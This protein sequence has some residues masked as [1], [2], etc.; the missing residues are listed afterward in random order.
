[1]INKALAGAV[2]QLVR[3]SRQAPRSRT[4]EQHALLLICWLVCAAGAGAA[5]P[6]ATPARHPE[7]GRPFIRH[8]A[9]REYRASD[10]NWAIAQDDRGVMYVGNNV[11][12]L[13][14][15]GVS[16]RLIQVPNESVIRSLAKDD[17]GRIYVGGLGEVGYLAPDAQGQMRFV[18]LLD[19][20]PEADRAFADVFRTFVTP[21]GVYF[22]SQQRLF[23]WADGRMR[24][25]RPISKFH[26]A[27]LVGETL[28]IGQPETG[29]MRMVG[30]ALEPL[31]DGR[32]FAD[33][34]FPV[35]LPLGDGQILIG[36]QE[37]GLFLHDGA[38]ARP[39]PTE[40]DEVLRKGLYRGTVLPDGTLALATLSAGLVIV[41][42]E[43][44]LALH[45]AKADGLMNETV[46]FVFADRQGA[47]W[48][49]L[50]SGIARVETPSPLSVFDLETSGL[51]GSVS[52]VQRHEGILYVATGQGVYRL[53]SRSSGDPHRSVSASSLADF[54]RIPITG[55]G[56]S[57]QAWWFLSMDDPERKRPSQL[58]VAVNEGVYRIEGERA[59]PVKESVGG[60][61]QPSVLCR[62]RRDPNRVF[63]GLFDGLASLRL[64]EGKWVDEGRVAGIPD[65]VRTI[66]E[67]ED[68]RLWLGTTVRGAVR[69]DFSAVIA[70]GSLPLHPQVERFGAA[71]GLSSPAVSVRLVDGKPLFMTPEEI[72]R[73][74]EP[75]RRFVPDGTF[76]VVTFDPLGTGDFG[77]LQQDAQGRVWING[78]H[79]TAVAIRQPDGSYR[80]EKQPFLRFAGFGVS[81]VFADADGVVWLAGLEGLVR[82]DGNLH[83]DYDADFPA[84][85]RRVVVNDDSAM[86][87]GATE[88]AGGTPPRL[89][90]EQSALRFEFAAPSFDDESA[91]EYQHFLEGHDRGW[92][93]WAKE[94]RR[95][96]TN[97]PF[98]NYQFRVRA[99]NRYGHESREAGY[100]F[101]ILPPWYRTWWAYAAYLLAL[102]AGVFVVDRLQRRRVIGQ[103]RARSRFRETQLR[104]E[105][106]ETLARS[107]SERTRSVELLSE[108]G[109]EIT[110]SLDFDTISMRLYE[111]VNQLLDATVVGVGLYH[112]KKQEIEY[113]LAVER[114]K[115]YEPYVRNTG[116]K[117]QF[118]V[119]CIDNRKPVFINDVA[120]EWSRYLA[121][122]EE[123]G[124]R[125]E[126]GSQSQ[127]PQSLL[128][129]PLATSD[130][131][132]GV[133][134]V[135][136]FQKNAYTEYHLNLLQNLAAYTTI[137]L[138]NAYTYRQ[139][140]EQESN[141]RQR[142]AEL[143]TVN[144][145]SQALASELKLDAL[146]PLVGEQVRQVFDAQVAYVALIDR[147]T[148]TIH[149]PY[150][151]GD[152]FGSRPH[153]AGMT[154][155]IIETG[156]PLLLNENI[157]EHSAQLKIQ[158]VGV[159][160]KSYLGV[161]ILVG[162]E[163]IGV[164]SVQ[165][166]EQEGRFGDTDLRLLKTIAANV[167]VAI[168]NARLFEET[169]QARATAE[170]ADA[171]KSSFLSTVSHELRTPLTSVLGFAKIIKKR[172]E[173]RIFPLVKSEDKKVRQ[174]MQ[175]VGDNLQVVVSEGE[176]LTK[177][178]DDVLDLAKI[179]A[180]KLEW[181]METLTVAEIVERA[182]AATSSLLE[183]RGLKLVKDVKPD[184]P[185]VVGDRDRLIQVVINLIS[186][187]VKF[188]ERGSVTCRAVERDGGV[189]VSV[190]DTGMGIAPADQ[191]KVFERFKQVGDTL[192]DK[193][194]GTGLGLPICKEIVEHHGGRVWVESEL[195]G[196]STFSFTL[197]AKSERAAASAALSLESLVK[198]LRERVEVS[199][200]MTRDGQPAIL[201]VDDDP[202]IRELLRQELGEAGY[203]IRLAADGREALSEIRRERPDLVI[204]D[205]MMPEINGFDVAA[206]LRNDPLTMDIPIMILSIVQD[207]ER[208]FRLGVDRYLTK[209]IDTEVLFREV[210]ALL[211][212][213]KSRKRVLVV[214][215]DASAAKTLAEVLQAR[216]YTVMEA[217]GQD[218]VARA[219]EM[220]P[221]IIILSSLV[222]Q[223]HEAVQSLRF[224]KGLENVLFLVYQ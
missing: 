122:Y 167:G 173:E 188:T 89:R 113:R 2:P 78:G 219:L 214:D 20:V 199:A 187:A 12:V 92:S 108:I 121:A 105:A 33:E 61:F 193:P 184:L 49:G 93:E 157:D 224:E 6:A 138:E 151:Y 107:E 212:Q 51:R 77:V 71:E 90:S 144:S 59:T 114:G 141:I 98:G 182:T 183:T 178:I 186:N 91:N 133:I 208:G 200:P 69:V 136:S 57:T 47:L 31:P 128:Y 201:A 43:G 79:E 81:S 3:R 213:G 25:W 152:T 10:Q 46:R 95:D 26:R 165:S 174:A 88:A 104:A 129:V 211:E 63:V 192:T 103:E 127:P 80:I 7:A 180:G 131:V 169:R 72:Y 18:S 154:S 196:G 99:R 68:G 221:D 205:V 54:V 70:G 197:P 34:I 13:E 40:A 146:I 198:Q 132:L 137:A 175:Q 83:K 120:S 45:L 119:W 117:N 111:R 185:E 50:D 124:R 123:P 76:K 74:E 203:R 147:A 155:R 153:G 204:L 87:S 134:S 100:A 15:D 176:R 216:G 44:H 206:V 145:I 223:R 170:E 102:A 23:R 161:P 160:S 17:A 73:F 4:I 164:I 181:H 116:D 148:N 106:A 37:H 139:L 19:K 166:T 38:S 179:E 220:Q 163:V 64:R 110:A 85:I 159:R 168:Q 149:F 142:A 48:L 158:R 109:K 191:P 42:R 210:G 32:R 177:L 194:K 112:A 35:I 195:G 66:A 126:N 207:R 27:G 86:F 171:A 1:L 53:R 190:I 29:L 135:Q 202:H 222:S 58:L 82:Y 130:R 62:S 36:T 101:T 189:V 96:Y 8:Y 28:Y 143:A 118:A 67:A 60:S 30:D 156:E 209:P 56:A 52:A 75:K 41:D 94:A 125:L 5:P 14:Y 65:E 39:F 218:L 217:N 21:Q 172:L 115:R 215:E 55:S 84:L 150:G 16:W 22:Q 11:G 140:N 162:N 24:V 97:L 9:R